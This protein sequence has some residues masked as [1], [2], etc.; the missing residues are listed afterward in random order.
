MPDGL[1]N[2]AQVAQLFDPP[3]SRT[4]I[5]RLARERGDFAK[6]A[7]V[8]PGGRRVWRRQA[9]EQWAKKQGRRLRAVT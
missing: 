3:V 5:N 8:F 9:V 1:L 7:A 6:P 4:Y 2:A